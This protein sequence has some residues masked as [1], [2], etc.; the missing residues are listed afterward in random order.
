M[1]EHRFALEFAG[2]FTS[3]DTWVGLEQSAGGTEPDVGWAWVDGTAFTV[4]DLDWT[5]MWDT[6][7]PTSMAAD[8]CAFIK[9]SSSRLQDHGC[10][11]DRGAT[12]CARPL[13]R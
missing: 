7:E 9:D 8:D 10:T 1:L 5:T 11:M 3:A 4:A 13:T 2:N 12:M 6:G